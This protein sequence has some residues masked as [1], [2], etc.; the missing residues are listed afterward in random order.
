MS[1]LVVSASVSPSSVSAPAPGAVAHRAASFGAAW[2]CVRPSSRSFSGWVVACLFSC[3]FAARRFA[4]YAAGR[5][6]VPFCVVRPVGS[7]FAVSVPAFVSSLPT[8]VP[9]GCLPV[10]W[11]PLDSAS[12][13]DLAPSEVEVIVSAASVLG[14]SGSRSPSALSSA[15]LSAAL[16]LAP[17]SAQVCV[18]CARGVD[19]VVRGF[20]LGASVFSVASGQFGSGRGAFAARSV[21]C[22]RAVAAAGSGGLWLSFPAG[23]CPAGLSPSSSSS[24]CFSG[25]GSGS[26]ASLAFAV[27]LG[28]PSAVFLESGAPPSGWGFSPLSSCPGWF[29]FPG[30]GQLSL[31]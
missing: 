23:A 21:A 14:F 10:S 9:A 1:T 2:A 20:F 28:V 7:W 13:P 25:S 12:V 22:V 31:L 6:S 18:G 29:F 4:V 17:L 15:A 26:W 30:S 16:V 11:F 8:A 5:L 24:R 19:A 3:S 27:G